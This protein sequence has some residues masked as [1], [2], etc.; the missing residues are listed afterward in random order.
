MD[1]SLSADEKNLRS[2]LKNED[3]SLLFTCICSEEL[4]KFCSDN[5]FSIPDPSNKIINF[6][7]S[8]YKTIISPPKNR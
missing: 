4:K 3:S 6:K 5:K 2:S 7:F 1:A 8:D